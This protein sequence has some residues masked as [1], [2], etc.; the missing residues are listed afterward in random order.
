MRPSL[1]P[2]LLTAVDAQP[3]SRLRRCGA[4]RARPGLSRR[5]AGGSVSRAPPACAP[6]PP[7]SRA[8]AA[9]GTARPRTSTCSTPRPTSFAVLAALGFDPAKAQITRDAPAWYHPG[10]SGT[11]RLGPKVVLAHFGEMHPATLKALDV[12]APVAGFEIFLDALPPRERRRAAPSRA[13]A[14]A[15]LLPVRRDF[16]FVLD[17]RRRGRRRGQAPQPAPTRR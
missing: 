17:R 12:A 1:L 8:A 11:L 14:A 2:G 3:Q 7:S 16:A 9:T 6:A 4:V 13:L 15:D 5:G 10:R